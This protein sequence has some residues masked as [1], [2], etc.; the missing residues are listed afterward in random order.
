MPT[1][2]AV[3]PV[4]GAHRTS[5]GGSPGAVARRRRLADPSSN[6]TTG[7]IP[8]GIPP[9][10]RR[11][12]CPPFVPLAQLHWRAVSHWRRLGFLATILSVVVLAT[13]CAAPSIASPFSKGP[14]IT[15]QQ[16]RATFLRLES[17]RTLAIH[18]RNR[19]ALARIETGQALTNDRGEIATMGNGYNDDGE[20]AP[21]IAV[22]MMVPRLNGYPAWFAAET[23]SQVIRRGFEVIS[24][25]GPQA[26]WKLQFESAF[27]RRNPVVAKRAG[28]AVPATLERNLS[29][30]LAIYHEHGVA[31]LPT[32]FVL[33]GPDTSQVVQGD[34]K[35]ISSYE[36]RGWSYGLTFVA[37]AFDRN[38]GLSLAGG[39]RLGFATYTVTYSVA[40]ADHSCFPEDPRGTGGWAEGGSRALVLNLSV[41]DV[42]GALVIETPKG[43]QVVG[44]DVD[45]FRVNQRAC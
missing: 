2:R 25:E 31:R 11:S 29:S 33:P 34:L 45:E 10:W 28:Y 9:P 43:D 14:V 8:Q 22:R 20:G 17:E 6:R 23:R 3:E 18:D 26:P 15:P 42:V 7:A 4:R 40:A 30:D 35:Q 38:E 12:L 1:P 19:T 27:D 24:R 32:Q 21:F 44:Q 39:G 37:G 16:A 41:T 36:S 13:A 5:G